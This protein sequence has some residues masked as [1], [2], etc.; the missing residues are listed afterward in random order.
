MYTYRTP[1]SNCYHSIKTHN[2]NIPVAAHT[3][4]CKIPPLSSMNYSPSSAQ[5]CLQCMGVSISSSDSYNKSRILARLALP[6][7]RRLDHI[8]CILK[9][10]V[11]SVFISHFVICRKNSQILIMAIPNSLRHALMH[12]SFMCTIPIFTACMRVVA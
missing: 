3:L 1:H 2:H 7:S 11:M 12:L 4:A 6:D 8:C 5:A 10:T 9:P